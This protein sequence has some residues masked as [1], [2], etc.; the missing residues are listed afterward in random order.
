MQG[1]ELPVRW[2]EKVFTQRDLLH[3]RKKKTVH[4]SFKDIS[5]LRNA[6]SVILYTKEV[7][8]TL[9]RIMASRN[10]VMRDLLHLNGLSNWLCGV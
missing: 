5:L 1:N 10:T 4:K 6:A 9:V 8:V 2:C 3:E 7:T